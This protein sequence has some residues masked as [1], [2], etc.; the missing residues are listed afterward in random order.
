MKRLLLS[1]LL[2]LTI[3]FVFPLHATGPNVSLTANPA[4]GPTPLHVD[5][6]VQVTG[7]FEGHV[8]LLMY[9]EGSISSGPYCAE[10]AIQVK[11]G[12]SQKV[13]IELVA[14]K[15]TVVQVR[16]YL[17]SGDDPVESEPVTVIALDAVRL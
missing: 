3:V 8:C 7:P 14:V 11:A 4:N 17:I 12:A 16:A 5:F 15:P 10:D 13:D 6:S 9:K 2:I 1:T